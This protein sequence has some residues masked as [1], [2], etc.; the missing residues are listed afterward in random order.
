[1]IIADVSEQIVSIIP[2]YIKN[3]S[4]ECIILKSNKII[5]L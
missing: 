5:I 2:K 1:M 4:L 3:K